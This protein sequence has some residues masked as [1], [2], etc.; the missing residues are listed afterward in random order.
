MSSYFFRKQFFPKKY[1]NRH[2]PGK[3]NATISVLGIAREI[4]SASSTAAAAADCEEPSNMSGANRWNDAA[5]SSHPCRHKILLVGDDIDVGVL[6]AVFGSKL[7]QWQVANVTPSEHSK[8]FSIE[9]I[10][11]VVDELRTVV[12]DRMMLLLLLLLVV[13]KKAMSGVNL[14]R[15]CMAK[16][17]VRGFLGGQTGGRARFWRGS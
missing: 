9:V 1:I 15:T 10:I 12:D 16:V 4:L 3:S 6:G 14:R 17:M 11:D 2:A 7:D 5:L 8:V 13:V